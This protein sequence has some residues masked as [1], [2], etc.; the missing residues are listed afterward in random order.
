MSNKRRVDYSRVAE[1]AAAGMPFDA[2]ANEIGASYASVYV[3]C[4]KN[5]IQVTPKTA[6][7][8]PSEYMLRRQVFERHAYRC[9]TCGGHHDLCIDHIVPESKG[10]ETVFENLQAMC[11]SCNSKK[12]A[13]I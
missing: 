11:R 8:P 9:V 10:G 12:G 13:R 7:R 4:R 1:L 5:R 3:F 6:L 2:I